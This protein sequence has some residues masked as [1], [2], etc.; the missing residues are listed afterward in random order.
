MLNEDLARV[1]A[2]EHR[3]DERMSTEV[4]PIP[5]GY[6]YLDRAF[7]LRYMANFLFIDD[8]SA[9]PAARWIEDADRILGDAGCRHRMAIFADPEEADRV[10][11]AFLEDGYTADGGVL[12]VHR[13]APRRPHG[14]DA[15]EEVSFEELRPLVEKMYRREPWASDEATVQALVGYKGKLERTIGARFFVARVDGEPA[16]CCELYLEGDDAQVES[17]DTL[18]EYRNRGLASATVLRAAAEARAGGASFVYLWADDDDW[19]RHWY[20]TLGFREAARGMGF[21]KWPPGEG[22][23]FWKSP[24]PG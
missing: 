18:E 23:E 3:R 1:T 19:P 17:V 5:G 4:V 16:S 24:G 22:P 10:S 11:M 14:I 8:A 6:A 2:F 21:L 7:T 20:A 15:V 13:D 12:L 9:A